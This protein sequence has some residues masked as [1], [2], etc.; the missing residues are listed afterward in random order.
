MKQARKTFDLRARNVLP[1]RS[2][3]WKFNFSNEPWK[4]QRNRFGS[5]KR[6]LAWSSSVL[7][8]E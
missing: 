8:E 2:W 4:K 5:R 3:T 7:V 1:L 6:S